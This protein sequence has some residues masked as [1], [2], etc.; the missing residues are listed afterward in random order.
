M[1]KAQVGNTIISYIYQF[2]EGILL[3]GVCLR[4]RGT[5]V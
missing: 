2:L 5:G 3:C 1:L 4:V